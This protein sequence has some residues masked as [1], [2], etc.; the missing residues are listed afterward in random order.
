[1]SLH[2]NWA[3]RHEGVLEKGGIAPR[4]IDLGTRRMWVVSFT[5]RPL[6]PQGKSPWYL[7]DRRQGGLQSR[8]GRC[9]EEENSQPLPKLEP[10]IIQPIA[11]RYTTELY[12]LM[13]IK[14]FINNSC[15]V[16]SS[17]ILVTKK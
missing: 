3:P 16:I 4:I 15:I 1:L 6:Y 2:F 5:P 11:Q 8:F 9:G 14:A 10:P 17:F 7:F 13:K 12:L